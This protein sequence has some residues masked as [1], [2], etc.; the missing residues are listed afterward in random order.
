MV[1]IQLRPSPPRL[2]LVDRADAPQSVIAVVREGVAASDPRAP[3]LDLLNTALGGSFTSRLNM[4]LRE[5]HGYAYG[6][7]SAFDMRMS[8]GPF[9]A[10]AGV[11]T[12]KTAE[13]LKEFFNV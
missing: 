12:D 3:L 11:Q 7:T 5:K 9:A 2:V 1:R 6:A 13:A 10:A 4:N 8:P